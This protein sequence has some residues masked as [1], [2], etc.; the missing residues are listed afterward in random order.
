[1]NPSSRLDRVLTSSDP[2]GTTE[3]DRRTRF[4]G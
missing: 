1:M 2:C 3:A 4:S